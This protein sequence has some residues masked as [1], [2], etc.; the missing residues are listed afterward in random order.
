M[1]EQIVNL[2]RIETGNVQSFK[3]LGSMVNTNNTI[4]GEIKERITAE[5]KAYFAHK[6]PFMSKTI[7]KKS[8][9]KLYKSVIRPTVT[10]ATEM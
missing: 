5:N 10:Y 9:L 4:E 7:S 8:K 2:G 3:Y 1:K 6:M